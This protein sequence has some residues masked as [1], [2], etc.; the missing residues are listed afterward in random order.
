MSEIVVK[1]EGRKG[2]R[3]KPY[4]FASLEVGESFLILGAKSGS[5]TSN[6]SYW[7]QKLGREFSLRAVEGG[8][9]VWRTT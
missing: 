1:V 2:R 6:L 5:I 8:V 4:P 7:Y 3:H 9:R